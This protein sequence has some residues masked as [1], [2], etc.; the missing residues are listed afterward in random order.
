M[1][2]RVA[3]NCFWLSRYVER[4]ETYA[5]LL[6][7]TVGLSLDGS[8]SEAEQWRPLIVVCGEEKPFL[9]KHDPTAI[10]DGETVLDYMTWSEENPTSIF[11]SL[12][13]ARENLRT[14]RETASL[15]MW[16][17]LNDLW[18]WIN[19]RPARRMYGEDRHVFY[20]Q[21]R[22][23]CMLF[24]GIRYATMLHEEA[25][26]FMRLGAA[27]E[28]VS[29]T[30]RILDVKYHSLGPERGLARPVEAAQWLAALRSCSAVEPFF[31]RSAHELDGSAVAAFLLF[32][33]AFPRSVRHNLDRAALL[34]ANLRPAEQP[35]IGRNSAALLERML[36]RVAAMTIES[37]LAD[38]MHNVLT[39]VVDTCAELSQAVDADFFEPPDR[40][41]PAVA[42]S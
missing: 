33:P 34:L 20:T 15:E 21:I 24:D 29:Q 26:D 18:L 39:W 19:S 42:S 31:K 4:I 13:W 27:L 2:S 22:D 7:V 12:R 37:V 6:D 3:E 14:I 5:R 11:T 23:R 28:R 1:I 38:G 17:T 32:D 9:A 40:L 41:E 30:A 10:H 16:E 8:M 25:F 35:Q 36:S